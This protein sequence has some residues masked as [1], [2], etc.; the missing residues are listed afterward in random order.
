M[1]DCSA[2]KFLPFSLKVLQG[3][4]TFEWQLIGG[5]NVK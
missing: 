4:D 5:K 2:Q 3:K 1:V